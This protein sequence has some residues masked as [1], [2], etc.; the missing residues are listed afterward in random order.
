MKTDKKRKFSALD[1][2]LVTVILSVIV[3]AGVRLFLGEDG[4]FPE[5][6]AVPGEYTVSVRAVNISADDFTDILCEEH[7]V[8]L[9]G[10]EIMGKT[11]SVSGLCAEITVSGTMTDSGFIMGESTY[12]APNMNIEVR[13]FEKTGTVTVTDISLNPPEA[14]TSD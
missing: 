2:V 11:A 13:S 10:G 8:Y 3:C 12:L 9:S 7:D 14:N 5:D 1:A 6:A 4:L